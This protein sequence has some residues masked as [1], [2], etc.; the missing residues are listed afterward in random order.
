[1]PNTEE[2]TCRTYVIKRPCVA[3]SADDG[4]RQ[5]RDGRIVIADFRK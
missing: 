2:D 5:A 3:G 4:E 1:M